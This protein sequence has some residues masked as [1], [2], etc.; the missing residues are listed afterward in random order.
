MATNKAV[1][2]IAAMALWLAVPALAQAQDNAKCSRPHR[3]ILVSIPDR[4]LAVMEDGVVLRTFPVSV[5]ADYSPSPIGEFQIVSRIANPTYYHPGTVIPAGVKNPL[6]PRWMGLSVKG[7]GIH[8]TN[9]PHSIGKASSHGCIRL[10]NR[11]I[12]ALY[13]MV[14]VG[15]SVTIRA[16]RDPEVAQ[17]FGRLK[18][19]STMAEA[20]LNPLDNQ[21]HVR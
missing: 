1:I 16:E 11:D 20:Q 6:G 19:D 18:E 10:R 7:Y 2:R 9:A 12:V 15:D 21:R 5:G 4:Q 13:S 8:G 3:V 17:V 14:A